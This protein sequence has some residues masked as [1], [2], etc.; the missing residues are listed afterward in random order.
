MPFQV[1]FL[2]LRDKSLITDLGKVQFLKA[3]KSF[4][5]PLLKRATS[6]NLK[7]TPTVSEE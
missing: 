5:S 1:S 3:M 6:V 4:L 2:L 7:I